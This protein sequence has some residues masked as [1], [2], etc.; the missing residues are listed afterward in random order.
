MPGYLDEDGLAYYFPPRGGETHQG[1]DTLT[2]WLL[3]ATHEAARLNKAYALPDAVRAPMIAGLTAFVE[4]RVERKHWSPREDLDVRKLA[5]IEALAR[6][7]AARPAMLTS[8]TIAPNQWPTS[9]LIDWINILNRLQ[10]IPNQREQLSQAEQIL[11]ARL[12]VQGTRMSF[13]TEKDDQW[14]WLM[15]G[16]DVNAARLLLTV[17]D[18]PAWKDDLPR[19]VTGF[20]ARQ[21]GGAWNTTTANLWGGLA[22]EQFSKAHESTPVAGFTLARLG[23]ASNAVDWAKVT[24]LKASDPQGATHAASAFGAP[25]APG[26]LTNN[27]LLLP[28]GAGPATLSVTHEGSGKPWLTLQALAAVPLHQLALHDRHHPAE[29]LQRQRRAGHEAE[30]QRDGDGEEAREKLA[31]FP[32]EGCRNVVDRT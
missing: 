19:L 30:R 18:K 25:A 15:A 7:G 31:E 21:Q 28:W 11:R 1:S 8:L 9:A 5:A 22:L 26:M 14:W 13:S 20:I 24:R 23:A 12:T 16:G 10:G 32:L 29:S 4:G 27:T 17:V 3:A 2:A 6:Y